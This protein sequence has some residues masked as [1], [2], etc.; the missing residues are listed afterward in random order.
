MPPA[1]GLTQK[2]VFEH[3]LRVHWTAS[4]PRRS[5]TR[6][7]S[8]QYCGR[9]SSSGSLAM[10]AAMC[11]TP[12]RCCMAGAFHWEA[13]ALAVRTRSPQSAIGIRNQI[14]SRMYPADRGRRL[15]LK[16]RLRFPTAAAL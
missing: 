9:F 8:P 14:F 13:R 5:A 12:E 11:R 16:H 3:E 6:L 1:V 10:F 2:K 15:R 7:I 4:R